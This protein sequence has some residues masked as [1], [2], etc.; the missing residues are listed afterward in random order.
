MNVDEIRR[1]PTT[2]VDAPA[3]GP[4]PFFFPGRE[5]FTI[6]YRTDPE[7]LERAGNQ[8]RHDQRYLSPQAMLA[9]H[10]EGVEQGGRSQELVFGH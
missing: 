9:E 5:F 8:H 4:G 7:A 10:P 1:Q 3:Y 6:E 2:P